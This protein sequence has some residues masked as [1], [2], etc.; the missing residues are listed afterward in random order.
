LVKSPEGCIATL[1]AG[2]GPSGLLLPADGLARYESGARYGSGHAAFVARPASTDEVAF[3]VRSCNAHDVDFIV[4]GANTGLVGAA[5]PDASGRQCVLSL[6][7]LNKRF[8]LNV[9]NRSVKVSAGTTLSSINERLAPQGLWF[10]IDLGADPSIGGMIATNTGGTRFIRYGDVR[11]NVLGVEAVLPGGSIL[12]AMDTVRKNNT[13]LDIKQLFIG[14]GGRFGVITEAVLEVQPLPRET[15]TAILVPSSG[16]AVLETLSALEEA[17]GLQL[18]AF[19]GMSRT[20]LDCVF[21]YAPK[22]RNPFDET[23]PDYALLIE[24]SRWGRVGLAGAPIQETL[25]TVLADILDTELI[26]NAYVYDP[27][28]LWSIRHHIS[29]SLKIRGRV[30]ALDVSVPRDRFVRF[31]NEARAVV[32]RLAEHVLVADFGHVGDGGVHFNMIWPIEVPYR[33]DKV[34]ALRRAVYDI[35]S[36]HKGSFSAEH[37][38]GPFNARHY[39][40]YVPQPKRELEERIWALLNSPHYAVIDPS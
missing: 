17:F 4:Q 24:I 33:D 16:D 25:E 40:E 30:I 28:N 37:G 15:A 2:M 14:T 19:E 9:P 36:A 3:V 5:S 20:A 22:L 7:R 29:D 13:G 32:R 31:R 12:D 38:V 21:S 39:T 27:A 1:R 23:L 34:E 11:R 8:E 6:E 10:P 26:T 18:T 35:V